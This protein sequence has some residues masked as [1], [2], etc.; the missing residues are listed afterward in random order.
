MDTISKYMNWRNGLFVLSCIIAVAMAYGPLSHLIL[1]SSRGEYYSHIVM[2]PFVSSFLIYLS[3]KMIFDDQRYAPK[4]GI[5]IMLIGLAVYFLGISAGV[6]LN[7]NDHASVIAL[8][9]VIFINGAFVLS[10]GIEA[11]KDAIF[12][13]VFLIFIIPIPSKLMYSIIHFLQV[14]STEFTNMLL[15]LSGVPFLRDGFVFH[16]PG[17]SVEVAK[18]CS[19]IRSCLALFITALLAGHLFLRTWWKKILLVICVIPIAMFKNGVRIV[20]LTLLSVYVD[21][22]IIQSSLHREG[23]IPFF[24]VALLLMAPI[25]FFLRKS[26]KKTVNS[27]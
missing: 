8:S 3:R 16:L 12:P 4:Q 27:K 9:A 2:I 26:E 20:S 7:D 23:G 5:P 19:G 1:S 13:L 21:P 22:R 6:Q 15:W 24:I 14:G 10:Y 17:Q 25:L 18:E 11:F